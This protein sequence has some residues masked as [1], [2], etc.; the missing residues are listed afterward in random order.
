MP[1]NHAVL[2]AASCCIVIFVCAC[3]LY[4]QS[5]LLFPHLNYTRTIYQEPVFA[6]LST[7]SPQLTNTDLDLDLSPRGPKLNLPE[8]KIHKGIQSSVTIQTWIW[9]SNIQLGVC[10]PEK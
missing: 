10:L 6:K 1:Q 9:D 3:I 4:V 7:F 5:R 8:G 2:D